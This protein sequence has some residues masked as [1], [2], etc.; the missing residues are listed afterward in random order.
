MVRV[1]LHWGFQLLGEGNWLLALVVHHIPLHFALGYGR[2]L[3]CLLMNMKLELK[4]TES[5]WTYQPVIIGSL[6]QDFN[7]EEQVEE[8]QESLSFLRTLYLQI[9]SAQTLRA[10]IYTTWTRINT[11]GCFVSASSMTKLIRA[12][13][14]L[15]TQT[16]R[17]QSC[18]DS[19]VLLALSTIYL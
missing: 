17:K 18:W 6:T 5:V 4:D 15:T 2:Y 7:A 10:A 9:S 1:V 8:L 3:L 16:E 19:W 11:S 14:G 12:I 13:D